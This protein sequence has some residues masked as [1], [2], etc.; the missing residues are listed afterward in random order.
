MA[1]NRRI[2]KAY[3]KQIKMRW[4]LVFSIKFTPFSTPKWHE[5]VWFYMEL[6]ACDVLENA[7]IMRVCRLIWKYIDIW[8]MVGL[9]RYLISS[10]KPSFF[11]CSHD[12]NSYIISIAY[13][14]CACKKILWFT[15]ESFLKS[16][17][18]KITISRPCSRKQKKISCFKTNCFY[19]MNK[20][21][22][23]KV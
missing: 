13:S 8:K 7:V 9:Q 21:I 14:P 10:I 11:E 18:D 20:I 12:V 22:S 5:I 19:R 23:T 6:Y 4:T 1:L 15:W 16:V 17:A 2:L 3:N